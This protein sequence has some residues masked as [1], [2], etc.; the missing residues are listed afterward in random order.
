MRYNEGVTIPVHAE[1][2]KVAPFGSLE[3]FRTEEPVFE[4]DACEATDAA[5]NEKTVTGD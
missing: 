1:R 3:L 4:T 2:M 5:A